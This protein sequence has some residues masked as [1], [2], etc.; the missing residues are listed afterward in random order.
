ME[1][2]INTVSTSRFIETKYGERFFSVELTTGWE[3][4]P[5]ELYMSSDG[6]N[7]T[8][9]TRIHLAINTNSSE[10]LELAGNAMQ[11]NYPNASKLIESCRINIAEGETETAGL[12]VSEEV[13]RKMARIVL[14][15]MNP[16][17]DFRINRLHP[18]TVTNL[19]FLA[20]RHEPTD[21]S[22]A[23]HE[24]VKNIARQSV[25]V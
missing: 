6:A 13:E 14:A 19:L 16:K 21:D 9:R 22:V 8:D 7:S 1:S 11:V 18:N 24:K 10:A 17:H 2:R 20:I 15:D 23:M 12:N 4:S 3:Y 5:F 25:L